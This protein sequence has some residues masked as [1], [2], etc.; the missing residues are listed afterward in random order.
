M[1]PETFLWSSTSDSFKTLKKLDLR[2]SVNC[3]GP[4]IVTDPGVKDSAIHSVSG[5]C[6]SSLFLSIDE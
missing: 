5:P 6:F 4:I 2:V 1:V 3:P